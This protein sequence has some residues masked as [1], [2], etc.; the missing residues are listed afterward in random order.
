MKF[1]EAERPDKYECYSEPSNGNF[2]AKCTVVGAF[3]LTFSLST[4]KAYAVPKS[5]PSIEWQFNQNVDIIPQGLVSIN[6]PVVDMVRLPFYAKID[7]ISLLGDNWDGY[8]SEKPNREA[9]MN[10]RHLIKTLDRETLKSLDTDAIYPSS[11]GSLIL[12]FDTE[13]GLVSVEIGDK[14][15]GFFTDFVDGNNY[16]AEGI[17]T[18]FV[19]VPTSLESCL[20]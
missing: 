15:M 8:G 18:D 4:P 16:A 5:K 20:S 19:S 12:D 6:A 13:R 1:V 9:I 2:I 17:S 3:I 14:T 11:Y 7:S 10:A